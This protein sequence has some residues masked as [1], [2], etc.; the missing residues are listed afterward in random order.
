LLIQIAP[1]LILF[2][3]SFL[4]VHTFFSLNCGFVI[5]CWSR[6][7]T[8][9]PVRFHAGLALARFAD[10]VLHDFDCLSLFIILIAGCGWPSSSSVIRIGTISLATRTTTTTNNYPITTTP[11]VVRGVKLVAGYGLY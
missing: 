5:S 11:L 2:I 8:R 7:V 9:R 10:P 1:L 4:T 3:L 6:Q